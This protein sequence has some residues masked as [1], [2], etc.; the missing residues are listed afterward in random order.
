M[1]RGISIYTRTLLT[2]SAAILA[3]FL[4]LAIVYG[5]VYN[6]STSRQRQEELKRYA[7]ELAYLTERR[8]DV[9]YTT[10]IS[11]DI[12]GYIS[13]ATRSTG[14]YIWVVNSGR[15]IIYNTGIPVDTIG[16]LEKNEEGV[17]ADY[18]LPET[19]CNDGRSVY[20]RR[21]SQTSFSSLL[22]SSS[23]WLVASAPIGS[24]GDLYTGEVLLLKRHTTDTF[25]S[26][27]VENNVHISFAVAY[28]VSLAIIIWLSRNIT[29][30]IS[31]LAKTANSVYLGDLTARVQ[32]GR[33]RATLTLPDD[34]DD[35]SAERLTRE[36]DLTRL[37]RTFN[38]L[39]SKFE[40]RESEHSEFLGNVSHDLRTPVTSIS[41]FIG[42]MLDGTIPEEKYSYYLSI[43]NA[44]A[45]RLERLINTLF[46]QA[47]RRDSH[48]L[49]QTVFDLNAW[50]HQVQVS[51]EPMLREKNIHLLLHPDESVKGDL[52]AL[53]D[54]GQLTRVLNNIVSNA[55]RFAPRGGLVT[56][57]TEA[58]ERFV[59]VIIEDNGPGIKPEDLPYVFD[60]FY[61]ADKSRGQEGSGLGL[62]IA[63]ALINRHG[64]VIQAG[65]SS[66]LGGAKIVFT[67]ARP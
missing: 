22:P 28:L 31:A 51:F 36:D 46:E 47:D 61:K 40:A 5:T 18:N 66:E 4:V 3:V 55:I 6:I 21:G 15:E 9:S 17:H 43:I 34:S 57:S 59:R 64:Q 7:Q 1:K 32:L 11:S 39:I 24:I 2:I 50:I 65:V 23:T 52:K 37:V 54:V 63:R 56:I 19:A 12:T 53:G 58:E 45:E 13:F 10:F 33:E 67:I 8:M 14:A 29:N 16:E 25:I 44:E 48:E 42:G 20:C 26:W 41:G 38:T 35:T 62:Y 30:P 49:K 27:L 60:R